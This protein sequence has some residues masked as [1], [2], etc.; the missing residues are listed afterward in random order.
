MTAPGTEGNMWQTV[1]QQ[2]L[3][4]GTM[5]DL[6]TGWKAALQGP[7]FVSAALTIF[8]IQ[9]LKCENFKISNHRVH[10]EP[11]RQHQKAYS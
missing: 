4:T 10:I 3:T 7:S 5:T 11:K 1:R 6:G 9:I 8:D 2:S